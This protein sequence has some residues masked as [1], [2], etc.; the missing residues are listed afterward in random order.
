MAK[1]KTK[2]LIVEDEE[3]LLFLYSIK[4]EQSGYEVIKASNGQEGFSLAKK[5]LPNLILLDILMP[6]VDGYEMLA[7]L[8]K[9]KATKNIPAI[10]FSNLSQK[11]EIEKGLKLGAKDFIIKTS[12]T[13]RELEDKVK[14]YLNNKNK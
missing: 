6:E 9:D 5:E 3:S 2:I 12:I 8:K 11:D 13:P 14:E 4:L 10:I 1:Q 7:S